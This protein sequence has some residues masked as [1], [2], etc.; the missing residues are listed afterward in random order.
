M[1]PD[2]FSNE[3]YENE[4]KLEITEISNGE[5]NLKK[6]KTVYWRSCNLI[7]FIPSA[8]YILLSSDIEYAFPF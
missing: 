1:P 2:R 3:H 7:I 8:H 5:R 6:C 4:E